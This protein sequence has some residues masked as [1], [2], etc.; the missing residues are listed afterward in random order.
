M[1]KK[2]PQHRSR[3]SNVISLQENDLL[4]KSI[5]YESLIGMITPEDM[6][7][8]K[9]L[10][11]NFIKSFKHIDVEKKIALAYLIGEF[12]GF[13]ELYE[14]RSGKSIADKLLKVHRMGQQLGMTQAILLFQ[15]GE[16]K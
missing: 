9:T 13:N 15:Q 12:Q 11:E 6:A 8:A 14:D 4:L 10:L 7:K 1:D 16:K 3:T 2:N 5:G